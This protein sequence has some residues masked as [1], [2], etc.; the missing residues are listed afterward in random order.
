MRGQDISQMRLQVVMGQASAT[1]MWL[2]EQERDRSD[3]ELQCHLSKLGVA[4]ED[5]LKDRPVPSLSPAG[6]QGTAEFVVYSLESVI[7]VTHRVIGT[8]R[9]VKDGQAGQHV[10]A[11]KFQLDRLEEMLEDVDDVVDTWSIQLDSDLSQRIEDAVRQ[12][13]PEKDSIDDWR[14]TLELVS[15]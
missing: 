2:D 10:G 15:D 7:S 5:L 14:K 8:V 13:D 1:I 6:S 11:I 4:L 3:W 12:I 9:K